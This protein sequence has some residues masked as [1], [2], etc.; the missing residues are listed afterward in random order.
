MF[1][2]YKYKIQW[3]L[4]KKELLP[5]CKWLW[6]RSLDIVNCMDSEYKVVDSFNP[7]QYTEQSWIILLKK[8][9]DN[10]NRKWFYRFEILRK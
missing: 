1:K 7:Y 6:I 9:A 5:V 8:W 2:T 10:N 3:V 4:E